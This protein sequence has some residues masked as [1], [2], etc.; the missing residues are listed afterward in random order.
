MVYFAF[1]LVGEC[2]G[3]SFVDGFEIPL[4]MRKPVRWET[5][6]NVLECP[7]LQCIYISMFKVKQNAYR[8]P[9]GNVQLQ[10]RNDCFGAECCKKKFCTPYTAGRLS[11]VQLYD[12]GSFRWRALATST[13]STPPSKFI[14]TFLD[15]GCDQTIHTFSGYSCKTLLENILRIKSFTKNVPRIIP[16]RSGLFR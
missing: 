2:L 7:G 4:H 13:F 12:Y 9:F 5:L 14:L 6:H 16:G 11:S 10:F 15:K 1:Y 3:Q 8:S